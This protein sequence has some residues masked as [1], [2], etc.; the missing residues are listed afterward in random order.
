MNCAGAVMPDGVEGDEMALADAIAG[1]TADRGT[2]EKT[3]AALSTAA[4]FDDSTFGQHFFAV[5]SELT[6]RPV[7]V[8]G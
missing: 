4:C 5:I 1:I 3:R 6:G 8:A 7:A 2:G